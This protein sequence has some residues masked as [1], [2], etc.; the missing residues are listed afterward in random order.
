[1]NK[2]QKIISF[3][4]QLKNSSPAGFAIICNK[5]GSSDVQTNVF[6]AFHGQS[7][8]KLNGGPQ[9]EEEGVDYNDV[10]LKCLECGEAS[11]IRYAQQE[12]YG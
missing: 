12:I 1:M 4:Q 7:G 5:C 3:L 10:L 9:T 8:V 2:I 11:L 6:L